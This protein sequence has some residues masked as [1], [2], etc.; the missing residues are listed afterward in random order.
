[1]PLPR[2]VR[3]QEEAH[4]DEDDRQ[5]EDLAAPSLREAFG[6][7]DGDRR[8]RHGSKGGNQHEHHPARV[9]AVLH[10]GGHELGTGIPG[11]HG[12]AR[13]R[14]IFFVVASLAPLTSGI[15]VL[16][17]LSSCDASAPQAASPA[18]KPTVAR[19]Q[20]PLVHDA[21]VAEACALADRP[22]ETQEQR[23]VI[24]TTAGEIGR[25]FS[26]TRGPRSDIPFL[27]AS[28]TTLGQI[29]KGKTFFGS[30]RPTLASGFVPPNTLEEALAALRAECSDG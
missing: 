9:G 15:V 4:Q 17:L 13:A 27:L 23:V 10:P 18:A 7:Q 21:L 3:Q 30:S 29:P 26:G 12:H 1:M 5:S 6:E 8:Q 22:V 24:A 14:E 20:V 25:R 28:M 2:Q 19:A 11:G 16:L